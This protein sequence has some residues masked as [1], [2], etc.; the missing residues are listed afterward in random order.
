MVV[1][2]MEEEEEEEEEEEREPVNMR[3]YQFW[4]V[5]LFSGRA[6]VFKLFLL[7][8]DGDVYSC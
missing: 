8:V 6:Y 5:L 1:V 3:F 7:E 4:P 2:D